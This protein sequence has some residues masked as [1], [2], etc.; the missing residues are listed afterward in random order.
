MYDLLIRGAGLLQ[1]DGAAASLL[2][3]HDIAVRAGRIVAV[4]PAI[5]PG[6]AA[7]VIDAAGML[8]APGLVNAHAHAA[9]GLFRGV[10][11]D[12]PVDVWFNQRIWPM[13]TNLTPEDIYWGTLL[14]IAEMIEAGV[15]SFADHYFAMDEVA[16][17][18]DESGVR[19]LLAWTVFSGPDEEH[20]LQ[21]T[22]A[23][24]AHWHG[25][26]G[27]RI[28][29]C[30]G[31]HSPYTCTPGFLSL[32][33]SAARASG[34]GIHIHLSETAE[35]V[36]QSLAAHGKTPV[37]LAR[38]AGL[39][40]VPALVA[41]AAH[42]TAEDIAVFADCGVAVAAC[43]KTEM[44]LGVGVTPVVDLLGAGV[45]VGL[46]SDGAAS[47]SS[48]DILEAARLIALL[49]KHS[50]RDAQVLPVGA[51][52][53]LATAGGARCLG[54]GG[55]V[56]AL[57][58]GMQADIALLRLD[59]PHMQ[60]A[61]DLPAALLYSAQPADVDTLIVAGRVLMRGRRLLTIDK[62][63]VLRE[64]SARAGRLTRRRAGEQVATY[65]EAS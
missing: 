2:P 62:G 39:F 1:I 15:T 20:Q 57:Q 64:V 38:D 30:L 41:H 4:A 26:A 40:E 23:F 44:K 19:A 46:G 47:N 11:E 25:A 54:L 50:R 55:A 59:A 9:M 3:G 58:V 6:L 13:E 60:P 28:R 45:A 63:R 52:L 5:S 8:A 7:E 61:H 48:Y 32:V 29:T 18:V 49:E 10:A 24:A 17:A 14:G 43:P 31:P 42:L 56:G 36:S 22:L 33:S 65:P 53:G 12:V 16:R 21:D 34:L 27:G 35:Q 37:A 51:A